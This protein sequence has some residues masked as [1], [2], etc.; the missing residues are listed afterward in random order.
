MKRREFIALLGGL[1]ARPGGSARFSIETWEG[2]TAA[3]PSGTV[4][5]NVFQQPFGIN[6]IWN[7]PLGKGGGGLVSGGP[8]P[9]SGQVYRYNDSTGPVYE[10]TT[11]PPLAFT[12]GE[13]LLILFGPSSPKKQIHTNTVGWD[14]GAAERCAAK[15]TP[16]STYVPVPPNASYP[17][18]MASDYN[19]CGSASLTGSTPN[20]CGCILLADRRSMH[21]NQPMQ[22]CTVG[23]SPT[24]QYF[25]NPNVDIFADETTTP[26]SAYGSHGGSAMSAIGGAIRL[27]EIIPG[28]CPIV[29]G[30]ADVM[31]H[32]LQLSFQGHTFDAFGPFPKWPATNNDTGN[33]AL[34]LA[35]LP[36]FDINSLATV[37]GRSIA[38]SLINYGAYNVDALG[39]A[40]L[41]IGVEYSWGD[42]SVNCPTGRVECEFVQNWSYPTGY[43]DGNASSAFSQD[44]AS[45]IQ[46]LYCITNN[47]P[48]AI[49]GG[50]G[51][52][53]RLQPMAATA[54]DH[55]V[56]TVAPVVND[57]SF[58]VS[59]TAPAA[60]L[61]DLVTAT[62]YP[63]RWTLT[64]TGSE[65]FWIQPTTGLIYTAVASI[66]TGTYT[67]TA[68]AENIVGS[69][70][71]TITI[72]VT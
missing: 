52:G 69:N 6:S 56:I 13:E 4:L 67:L 16:T 1:T 57:N 3:P 20:G 30:V 45:I 46:N 7:T 14:G 31:R 17:S 71:G 2:V 28:N 26:K 33:E 72:T 64:G 43:N 9:H 59:H 60:Q 63:Y 29:S 36:T 32:A 61:I 42:S 24:T 12:V 50:A 27:K 37:P 70:S 11:V 66:T 55:G 18:G 44:L 35:L 41:C 51:S 10:K 40:G 5:R 19:P 49:G 53:G 68:T 25:F 62:N 39:G 22:I 23:G 15:Q 47:G 21:Q 48:T 54:I 58:L 34:L 8:G 38:W 65:N